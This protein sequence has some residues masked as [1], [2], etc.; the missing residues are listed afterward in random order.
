MNCLFK[1]TLNRCIRAAYW[2]NSRDEFADPNTQELLTRDG[3]SHLRYFN[4]RIID[5]VVVIGLLMNSYFD[6]KINIYPNE[7]WTLREFAHKRIS[8][9]LFDAH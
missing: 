9:N 7:L 6:R 5:S 3:Y 1:V 4:M 2:W 8:H